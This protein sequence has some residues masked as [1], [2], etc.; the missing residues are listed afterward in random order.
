MDIASVVF[1]KD[2]LRE[3]LGTERLWIDKEGRIR[4]DSGNCFDVCVCIVRQDIS[5]D[6]VRLLLKHKIKFLHSCE[7]CSL[8]Q[9]GI[10]PVLLKLLDEKK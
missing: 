9:E 6:C 2:K 5:L 7:G 10:I 1:D 8:S 4:D 3:F